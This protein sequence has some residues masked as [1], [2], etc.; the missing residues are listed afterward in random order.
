VG[1]TGAIACSGMNCG[2]SMTSGIG[3]IVSGSCEPWAGSSAVARWMN[4]GISMSCGDRSMAGGSACC[5][6]CSCRCHREGWQ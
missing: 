4:R 3:R 2:I 6:F 5:A 1:G